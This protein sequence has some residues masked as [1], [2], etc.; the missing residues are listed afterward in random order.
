MFITHTDRRRF[1]HEFGN[2]AVI[3]RRCSD[4]DNRYHIATLSRHSQFE[5][6]NNFL[7]I[8]IVTKPT[9]KYN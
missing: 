4:S 6:N 9:T 5:V 3:R 8:K 1:D 2:S 7:K